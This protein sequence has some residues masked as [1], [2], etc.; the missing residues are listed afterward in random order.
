MKP[1]RLPTAVI[2]LTNPRKKLSGWVWFRG[3]VYT[4]VAALL[5]ALSFYILVVVQQN[6]YIQSKTELQM[7][8]PTTNSVVVNTT[9]KIIAREGEIPIQIAKKYAIWVFESAAI[10]GV[11][12]LLILS[13]MQV[14]SRFDYRAISPTGPIGLLQVAWSWHKEKSSKDALF[15]P[16]T[17]I[18]VGTQIL[19]E[20]R[21]L[22]SSETELLLRYN[23][24]L[25]SESPK[26]A[27][28][29]LSMKSKFEK[30]ILTAV[31]ESI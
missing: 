17:N 11:D 12:P 27:I 31:A 19:K 21:K 1:T 28:K 26:Y 25:G 24:S 16:K 7:E 10:H 4:F 18:L 22:S 29:V 5:A 23:G 30:E 6:S 8:S 14:E 3:I 13:V 15:D 20:Y 9:A 2:P